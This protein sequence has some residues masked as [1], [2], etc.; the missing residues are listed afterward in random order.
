MDIIGSFNVPP[1]F[2]PEQVTVNAFDYSSR[3]YENIT[4]DDGTV[5]MFIIQ[6]S[7][8]MRNTGYEWA[9]YW[10]PTNS[11]YDFFGLYDSY[12]TVRRTPTARK[13]QMGDQVICSKGTLWVVHTYDDF[14]PVQP[15]WL[16]RVPAEDA[17]QDPL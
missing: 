10:G 7:P 12:D 15:V 3:D 13:L 9:Q 4:S 6:D 14:P 17:I 11:H 16:S 5:R 1:Y 8:E 2:S